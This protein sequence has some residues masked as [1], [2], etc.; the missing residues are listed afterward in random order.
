MPNTLN[1]SS[2][3]S[4]KRQ[5][6]FETLGDLTEQFNRGANSLTDGTLFSKLNEISLDQALSAKARDLA[7]LRMAEMRFRKRIPATELSDQDVFNIFKT[8]STEPV[9]SAKARDLAK[10]RMA[11][12]RFR[13]RIPATVFF[14]Q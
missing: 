8:R 3:I 1:I 2:N 7:K 14:D 5:D 4:S 10:L 6:I 13:N 12:M 9:L 11:E